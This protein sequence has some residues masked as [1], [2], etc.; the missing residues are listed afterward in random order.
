MPLP[1]DFKHLLGINPARH[2]TERLSINPCFSH[3]IIHKEIHGNKI[4]V[5]LD[6][7]SVWNR[8]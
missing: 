2:K 7:K 6:L 5:P 8:L 1:E 3:L 4:F